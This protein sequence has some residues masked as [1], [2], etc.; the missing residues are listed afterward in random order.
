MTTINALPSPARA[1]TLPARAGLGLKPAHFGEVLATRPGLGFFE[2]HAENYMVPGGPFHHAL[3]RIREHYP[4]SLHGVGLSIGGP[5]PLDGAHLERLAAL[6]RRYEPQ[7][8]SEHLAWSSHGGV[9][10]NDLL[11]VPYTSE[12]LRRVCGHID[13]VQ[14]RLGRRML[15]ENPATYI[16]FAASTW[17]EGDFIAEVVRRTGCGL[18]L[19]VNNLYVACANHGRDALAGLDAL[20]LHAVG[21]IHLAGFATQQDADG[22]PLLIDSHGSPVAQ[23]VWDLY[24]AALARVGAQPTLIERDNDIP[25]FAVLLAEAKQAERRLGIASAARCPELAA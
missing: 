13:T 5:G 14:S 15:L 17:A 11:P 16:E 4:L 2:V 24:D 18:L 12:T 8:F 1:D 3:T 21:E 10:L 25:P 9:F 6:L 19:D 22:A 20:P 23:A 7:S